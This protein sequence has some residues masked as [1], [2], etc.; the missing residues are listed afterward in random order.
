M[1]KLE[2]SKVLD[3]HTGKLQ[4]KGN[5]TEILNVKCN[6]VT[7]APVGLAGISKACYSVTENFYVSGKVTPFFRIFPKFCLIL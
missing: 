5:V 2:G 4:K 1:E 7:H 3:R 6:T